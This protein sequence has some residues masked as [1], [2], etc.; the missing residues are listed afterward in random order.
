LHK[1]TCISLNINNKYMIA[2]NFMNQLLI[3]ILFELNIIIK[4]CF[5]FIIYS[6]EIADQLT[7][8]TFNITKQG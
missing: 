5:K 2:I 4:T 1:F 7:F 6:F 8:I 3:I